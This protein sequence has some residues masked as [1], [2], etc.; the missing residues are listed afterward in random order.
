MGISQVGGDFSAQRTFA[1]SKGD[2]SFLEVMGAETG[3]SP[4]WN[5]L[6]HRIHGGRRDDH[7]IL[8]RLRAAPFAG[9]RRQRFTSRC[10]SRRR[11]AHRRRRSS[12]ARSCSWSGRRRCDTEL[13]VRAGG[14]ERRDRMRA[15][16]RSRRPGV[17]ARLFSAGHAG[18][19]VQRAALGTAQ[20][21]QLRRAAGA[22]PGAQ[23]AH[24][25]DVLRT[26]PD[27][28]H[29]DDHPLADQLLGGLARRDLL[30]LALPMPDERRRDRA[31]RRH[32][33]ERPT[34]G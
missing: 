33:R 25:H 12:R 13:S 9:R 30:E 14:S 29:P 23:P 10:S 4:A 18:G 17:V 16:A 26:R 8:H 34:A 15:A 28:P 5:H 32:R 11:S 22:R 27:K 24:G 1:G 2:P 6:L 20:V 19:R 31:A 7:R 3:E 21:A